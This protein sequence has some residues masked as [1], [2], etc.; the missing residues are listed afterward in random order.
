MATKAIKARGSA[1]RLTEVKAGSAAAAPLIFNTR[2]KCR[3]C[4]KAH[5]SGGRPNHKRGKGRH[6]ARVATLL[7]QQKKAQATIDELGLNIDLGFGDDDGTPVEAAM[8][9]E[10]KDDREEALSVGRGTKRLR[11]TV[12][13]GATKHFVN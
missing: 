13:S 12:D 2:K 10:E 9:V 11:F 5:T 3:D 8:Y 7:E 4:G 6:E 1:T